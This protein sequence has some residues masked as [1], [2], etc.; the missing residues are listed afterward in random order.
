MSALLGQEA[1]SEVV[2]GV[3]ELHALSGELLGHALRDTCVC[4]CGHMH[5]WARK[6]K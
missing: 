1:L 4:V 2:C 5:V 6:Q 3:V